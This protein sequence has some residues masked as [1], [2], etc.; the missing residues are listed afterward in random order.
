MSLKLIIHTGNY[1]KRQI[2]ESSLCK[3]LFLYLLEISILYKFQNK[4]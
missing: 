4:S 3:L 1:H 2:V